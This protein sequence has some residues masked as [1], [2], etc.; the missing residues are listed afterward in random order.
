MAASIRSR[1]VAIRSSTASSCSSSVMRPPPEIPP[2]I[3][4]YLPAYLTV[5]YRLQCCPPL[6]HCSHADNP[7]LSLRAE[8]V[9]PG[10]GF[11]VCHVKHPPALQGLENISGSRVKS[12]RPMGNNDRCK[13]AAGSRSCTS[14]SKATA[15]AKS[16]GDCGALNSPTGRPHFC[17]CLYHGCS[18]IRT[19]LS[20]LTH[21]R[22]ISLAGARLY[23]ISRPPTGV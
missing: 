15:F 20:R 22:H 16:S 6:R 3:G 21:R 10:A 7:A 5:W 2:H 17:L 14:A 8:C 12:T 19:P 13:N 11:G 9:D 18:P 23:T 1:A 4:F